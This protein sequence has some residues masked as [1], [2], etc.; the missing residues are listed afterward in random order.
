MNTD[1]DNVCFFPEKVPQVVCNREYISFE[2]LLNRSKKTPSNCRSE[3]EHI[4][5]LAGCYDMQPINLHNHMICSNHRNSFL[6]LWRRKNNCLLCVDVFGQSTR[7]ISSLQRITKALAIAAWNKRQLNIYYKLACTQCRKLC[8]KEFGS[9][10]ETNCFGWIYDERNYYTPSI[11]PDRFSPQNSDYEPGVDDI[12]PHDEEDGKKELRGWLASTNYRGRWRSTANY[13]CLSKHERGKFRKQMKGIFLHVL[14]QF[15]STD[16]NVVWDDLIDDELAKPKTAKGVDYTTVMESLKDAYSKAEHWSTKRQLLSIV[17]ADLPPRLLKAEFPELTDWKIKAARAQ[18][19]FHGRG[20]LPEIMHCPVQRYTEKQLS[21]L[22][23]FIQ[24]PH[25]TTDMPFG[26][27][28]LKLSNGE[29]VVVPDVIRN[30][31]P[32]RI[33]SQYFE[34]CK[35]TIDNDEFQPLGASSLFAILRKCSASIR[36]SLVG[37]DTFSCDGSTAF[38]Q[39]QNLCD[40]MALYGAYRAKDFVHLH[41]LSFLFSIGAQAETVIRL[42]QALHDARNYLKLDYRTHIS[43]SSRVPDHCSIFGL[44][45]AQNSA[46]REKCDHEHDEECDA[47]LRLREAFDHISSIIE[48]NLN[49][50][51]DMRARLRYRLEQNVQLIIDWKKHLLPSSSLPTRYREAQRDFFGKRGLPWHITYAIRVKPGS[52]ST[53]TTPSAASHSSSNNRSLEHRTFCHVFDNAKQ[54]GRAVISI[55]S[56][57]L[58]ELKKQNSNLTYAYI[59][60]DNAGCYKGSDTLLAV[61]ELYKITGVLVRRFDFSNAQSGKGPCDRMAAVIKANIRRFINEKNDCVSSSDFV[62]AAKSTRHMSLMSCRMPSSSVSNKTR[63]HGIQNYN[64][65]EYKLVSKRELRR[66]KI[67]NKEIEVTVWRAFNVGVGQLFQW[68]KLNTSRYNI[69]PIEIS[70]RHDNYQWQ[71]D[72]FEREG[73]ENIDTD[74]VL[75]KQEVVEN[76]DNINMDQHSSSFVTFDCTEP[77]CIMQF[78]REDRLRAHLL[79]GN[80]KTVAPPVRLLDKAAVIYKESLENDNIKEIPILTSI[81]TVVANPRIST[82]TLKEGW[83]L[84]HPRPKVTFTLVQR[85]YLIEK[86]DE[87]EKTGAKCDPSKLAEQMQT[88]R[89]KDEFMFQ[90]D[91]FLTTSQIKS[92]F[93]RLTRERRKNTKESQTTM[94]QCKKSAKDDEDYQSE[95]DSDDGDEFE[96][97]LAD[98]QTHELLDNAIEVLDDI[99]MK[100]QR[101]QKKSISYSYTHG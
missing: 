12:S 71:D 13:S 40:E 16:A 90:P 100:Q 5:L 55:L 9:A 23:T 101:N 63:W 52:F 93:S 54:D 97:V 28:K 58:Q 60:T 86:Y 69:A 75:F 84:F 8:E 89:I 48:E 77:H 61:Q 88:A 65:I 10:N 15:T 66:Q 17:A 26:E 99:L 19:F 44:S 85:S 49:I 46:W 31:S 95:E 59:R 53:C 78:R 98:A 62:R 39:L 18:A 83:A 11:V 37:L 50:T 32:S 6:D 47:C 36:K 30:I 22:I 20:V 79:I 80:H 1:K 35:E 25:I 64:N 68:S 29:S 24:S 3:L 94:K 7:S 42:K 74:D 81:N 51:D 27:R 45:D 72:S 2:N 92:Y 70:L 41:I 56:N 33:I 43:K 14:Q 4:L 57:V 73:S 91:Q 34:Y 87:G 38:D 82:V 76:G 67:E 21:H 96:S